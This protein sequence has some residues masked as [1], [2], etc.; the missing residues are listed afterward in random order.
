[1]TSWQHW[2]SCVLTYSDYK[3]V[4]CRADMPIKQDRNL[5]LLKTTT[6]FPFE[7]N[8]TTMSAQSICNDLRDILLDFQR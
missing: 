3:G 7:E 6:V 4:L 1:M 8:I 5:E 2:K